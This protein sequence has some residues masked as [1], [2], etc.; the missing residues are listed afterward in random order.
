MRQVFVRVENNHYLSGNDSRLGHGFHGFMDI[1]LG[2]SSYYKQAPGRLALL[3]HLAESLV[4]HP[5]DEATVLDY[6][7][8]DVN[9][10]GR[11]RDYAAKPFGLP[12]HNNLGRRWSPRDLILKTVNST[13]GRLKLQLETLAAKVLFDN[14][15]GGSPKASGVEFLEGKGVYGATWKYDAATAPRG[16]PGRAWARKEVILS[17]G[18]FN[19]P[20]LLQLSGIGNATHL[21][22]LGIEVV[23]DLPGVGL[24]LRDNQEIPVAGLSPLNITTTLE[25]PLWANCTYGAPDD[26]CLALWEVGQGPYAEPSG[27]SEC[28]FLTTNSSTNGIRD[29]ITFA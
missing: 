6:L 15:T 23:A 22:S 13:G 28:A 3:G 9:Y 29:V 10:D 19:S 16:T 5:L 4:G 24:N 25:D 7:D 27:N 14:S 17:G 11:S 12:D 18:A 21:R 26:P 2:N 1:G 8:R 20:Q